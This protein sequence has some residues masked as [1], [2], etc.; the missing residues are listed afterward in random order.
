MKRG[1]FPDQYRK[2]QND[3]ACEGWSI[4]K[5]KDVDQGFPKWGSNL[6]AADDQKRGFPLSLNLPCK[7]ISIAGIDIF[8]SST[9]EKLTI[10]C[11]TTTYAKHFAWWW[12]VINCRSLFNFSF[13]FRATGWEFGS[14]LPWIIWIMR[15]FTCPCLRDL[16]W[17]PA[18]WL[19][20]VIIF[21]IESTIKPLSLWWIIVGRSG[22]P[23]FT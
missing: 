13:T 7:W 12:P 1:W 17:H 2:N 4:K 21:S 16:F 18:R 3:C 20:F 10:R 14:N 19:D 22:N 5:G 9:W 15:H 6:P 23:M 11:I 8:I